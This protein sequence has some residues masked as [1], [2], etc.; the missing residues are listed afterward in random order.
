MSYNKL[1]AWQVLLPSNISSYSSKNIPIDLKNEL[2]KNG[3]MEDAKSNELLI[4]FTKKN[5]GYNYGSEVTFRKSPS[6][7]YSRNYIYYPF[8]SPRFFLPTNNKRELIKALKLHTPGSLFGKFVQKTF[9]GLATLNILG[10][11]FPKKINLISYSHYTLEKLLENELDTAINAITIY[12]GSDSIKRKLTLLVS[13]KNSKDFII[14]TTNTIEGIEAIQ[15]E[16]KHLQYLNQTTLSKYIPN[17]Y[18]SLYHGKYLIQIQ[19]KLPESNLYF[20]KIDQKCFDF[21]R[22]LFNQNLSKAKISNTK[23]GTL[24]EKNRSQIKKEFIF[25]ITK[26]DRIKY[27]S[28]T[29]HYSHGDFTP[30]NIINTDKNILVFD[31]EDA[32]ENQIFCYDIFHFYFRQNS[33]IGPWRGANSLRLLIVKNIKIIFPTISNEEI[34]NFW[35]LCIIN[36]FIHNMENEYIIE[37]I[38]TL[39]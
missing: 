35:L 33:L 24:I 31:W 34:E 37:L 1:F 27:K 16:T 32:N 15:S 25:L 29:T 6:S 9:I 2:Q 13:T 36:E 19:E 30:W 38:E 8:S 26:F 39:K 28:I 3:Y 18:K 21:L 20:K 14:K 10:S 4:N 11:I 17:Y 7:E 23:I 22:T 12:T 5:W